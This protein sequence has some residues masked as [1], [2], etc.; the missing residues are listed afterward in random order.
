MPCPRSS[1]DDPPR[2]RHRHPAGLASPAFADPNCLVG[3]KPGLRVSV[4]VSLGGKYTEA[5][6]ATFDQMRL[7]QAGIDADTVERTW[8]GCLKITRF[9]GGRWVTEY[10]DPDTLTQKPLNLRLP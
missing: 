10:Y 7:K 9:E 4:G 2:P 3:G 6:Q 8:L 1:F 5:E